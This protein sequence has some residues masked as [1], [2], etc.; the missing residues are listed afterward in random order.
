MCEKT[1]LN[2]N[3]FNNFTR[4]WIMLF[5]ILLVVNVHDQMVS[6]LSNLLVISE[7]KVSAGLHLKR[8][9]LFQAFQIKPLLCNVL[10]IKE[11]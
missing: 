3:K 8:Q 9:L 6:W 1:H 4:G 7:E 11:H 5:H 10:K 2:I